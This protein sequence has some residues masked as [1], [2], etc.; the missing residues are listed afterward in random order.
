MNNKFNTFLFLLVSYNSFSYGAQNPLALEYNSSDDDIAMT[1]GLDFKDFEDV[2]SAEYIEKEKEKEQLERQ[3]HYFPYYTSPVPERLI[4]KHLSV[5][6]DTTPA[7]QCESEKDVKKLIEERIDL[8][9]ITNLKV[10]DDHQGQ[11]LLLDLIVRTKKHE[12]PTFTFPSYLVKIFR[13]SGMKVKDKSKQ[14]IVEINIEEIDQ[15]KR[16]SRARGIWQKAALKKALK[17]TS[18]TSIT[19]YINTSEVAAK[20]YEMYQSLTKSSATDSTLS[21]DS[22]L[23]SSLKSFL[24]KLSLSSATEEE[25]EV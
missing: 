10:N 21:T 16:D 8:T 1:D 25:E 11:E 4:A 17:M 22:S 13:T 9:G 15:D 3:T 5:S 14:R 12:S 23:V 6:I 18:E 20:G 2:E 19:E 7:I 24:G